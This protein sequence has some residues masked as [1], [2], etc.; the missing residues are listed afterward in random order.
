MLFEGDPRSEKHIAKV[1]NCQTD[2]MCSLHRQ[3]VI[4]GEM[5][6]VDPKLSSIRQSPHLRT[7]FRS[8]SGTIIAPCRIQDKDNTL[9]FND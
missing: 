5:L 8:G 1:F 2:F 6:L 3:Q 9:R 7:F 4:S